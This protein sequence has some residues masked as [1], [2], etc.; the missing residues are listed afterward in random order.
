MLA[1]LAVLAVSTSGAAWPANNQPNWYS[2]TEGTGIPDLLQDPLFTRP[3]LDASVMHLPDAS[4]LDCTRP[5]DTAQALSLIEVVDLS[6]CNNP[7]VAAAWAS[8]KV[9][10]AALGEAR[11]SYL[12]TLNGSMSSLESTVEYPE[13][14]AL[15]SKNMGATSYLGLSWRLLDFAARY[16]NNAV[17]KYQLE[18]AIFNRDATLQ[19][20]MLSV[21]GAYYD[22]VTYRANYQLRLEAVEFAFATV[23]SAKLRLRMGAA[24]LNDVLVA[25][26]ALA[27]AKLTAARAKGDYDKAMAVL[28]QSMGL[29]S[30]S[31]IRL[32]FS[33]D[34]RAT[35]ATDN[36][37]ALIDQ[38]KT[39]HPAIKSAQ[40]QLNAALS[41]VDALRTEG[42]PSIDFSYN[43]Y[44]NGYP[45]QSLQTT[46]TNT[47][48][49]G[50]TLNIPFFE[51][52]ARTY[53]IRGAQ[54]QAEQ[55]QYQVDSVTQ[56]VL[57]DVVKSHADSASSVSNI[58]FADGLLQAATQ[59]YESS[60]RRYELGVADLPELLSAQ[61]NLVDA[62]QEHAR[63]QA[64]WR[65]SSL[66]LVAAVGQLGHQ[67]F[68]GSS[69]PQ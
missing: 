13:N 41:K 50:F 40:L 48:N 69:N 7:Q 42:L 11:A 19:K 2:R 5:T 28:Y 49:V 61:N 46:K 1:V 38:V 59:A 22:V 20:V 54:A 37:Q 53:K 66:K 35:Q 60:K 34:V 27:K 10:A 3:E 67:Q 44:Q 32:S 33:D 9:Q 62:K 51:G 56:Q 24:T 26:S 45:N 58:A 6:L 57:V 21:V 65:S 17:A 18:S 12:P 15:N 23:G 63:C 68:T 29:P 16:N 52:F 30:D 39:E 4:R 36:L 64:E 25:E 14:S 47:T 55:A 43:Y 8:I 31:P